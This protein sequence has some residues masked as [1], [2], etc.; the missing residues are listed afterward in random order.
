MKHSKHS[1]LMKLKKI[2][3]IT[4]SLYLFLCVMLFFL[5]DRLIFSLAYNNNEQSYDFSAD[6][7]ETMPIEISMSDGCI[8]RGYQIHT[9]EAKPENLLLYFG[10]NAEDISF[11][12]EKME[13]FTDWSI[14]LMNY[15]GYGESEGKPSTQKLYQDSQEIYDYILSNSDT[16]YD[17]IVIMG[18]SIGSS[19][20]TYLASTRDHSAVILISPFDTLSHVV[21]K[22]CPILPTGLVLK[23]KFES[24]KYAPNVT[25]HVY[26]L[27]GTD[28]WLVPASLT[29]ELIKYFN[30]EVTYTEIPG[31]GHNSIDDSNDYWP[32]IGEFLEQQIS[33]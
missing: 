9:K 17:N 4:L 30:G 27:A 11:L 7:G 29:K 5:Q 22:K 12:P 28:D 31:V 13:Q 20:A 32:L 23:H 2:L 1:S 10:A 25:S 6:S 26:I 19:V 33:S 15:R 14:I 18:R 3:L 16:A 21:T 8:L 24:I